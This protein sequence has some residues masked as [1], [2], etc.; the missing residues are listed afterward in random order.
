MLQIFWILDFKLQTAIQAVVDFETI[1]KCE[2][3][4]KKP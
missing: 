1:K 3:S 4:Y 2:S